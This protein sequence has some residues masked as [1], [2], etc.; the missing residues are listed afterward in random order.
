MNLH[1]IRRSGAFLLSLLLTLSLAVV[2]AAADPAPTPIPTPD[3]TVT[4]TGLSFSSTETEKVKT[5]AVNDTATLTV[6]VTPADAT[7]KL[8]WSVENPTSS[9]VVELVPNA[10]GRE[11]TVTAK[12]PGSATIKVASEGGKAAT[13][14]V[15]V[16]GV[17]LDETS[18]T[19]LVGEM[20][21]LAAQTYGK[22]V[23]SS[24][25]VV[26]SS[27]NISVAEVI[28]GRITGHYPGVATI[29][30]SAGSYSASCTVTV[31]EDVADAINKSASAGE[32]LSFSGLRSDFQNRS[33]DKLGGVGLS[34][35]GSLQV[36]PEQGVLYY[37]YASSDSPGAGVGSENYY[38]NPSG[39]QLGLNELCFVPNIDFSGTAVIYYT[40][41]GTDGRTFRGTVRVSVSTA[42]DVYYSTAADQP[43]Y[44]EAK[45]F[46][47]VCTA[48][49]GKEI[50]SISF[51]PPS[52]KKGV[53]HYNYSTTNVYNPEVSEGLSFYRTKAPYLDSVVF[54]PQ[55]DYSG[56]VEITYRCTT[57]AGTHTGKVRIDVSAA[58]AADSGRITYDVASGGQ[59]DLDADDFQQLSREKTGS[60]LSY[61]YFGQA[62]STGGT[63]YYNYTLSSGY[64]GRVSESTRYYRS[65]TPSISRITFV[66]S[67]AFSGEVTVPFTGYSTNGESFSGEM[68]IRVDEHDGVIAYRS[69]YGE[70]IEFEGA[71][72][73]ELCL[74]Q[75]DRTLNYVTFEQPASGK[76][77]L[78]R[79][80]NYSSGTKVNSTTKFYRSGGSYQIDDVVFVPNSSY[81][82]TFELPFSGYDTSGGRISGVVRITVDRQYGNP[83]VSYYTVSGGFVTFNADDL[84]TACQLRTG[85]RLNYVQF[86][87]PS[88]SVGKLYY[89]YDSD[90]ET[91][92]SVYASTSYYRT[93]SGRVI[94]NVSFRAADS[95]TGTLTV[96][97]TGVS[98]AGT[99]YSGTIEITVSAKEGAFVSYSGSSLPIR[100]QASDFASAHS[101]LT[102][103]TLSYIRFTELPST[104]QGKLYLNYTTPVQSGTAVTQGTSYY[105]SASPSIGQITFV[106]KAGY[107]GSVIL[108]FTGTDTTGRS[109]SGTL[110]L[111]LLDQYCPNNFTDMSGYRNVVPS[112]EFLR[113]L[114]VVKGYGDGTYGPGRSISR[115]EFTVMVYRALELPDAARRDSFPDVSADSYYADAV[116]AAKA[117]GI[118]QGYGNA[119]YPLDTITRQD[120]MTIVLRAMDATGR[121][122][123]GVSTSLLTTYA[124]GNQVAD[125][126][127]M[128]VS[129]FLAT[130][131]AEAD[132]ARYIRPRD[133]MTRAEMAVLLHRI[134]AQ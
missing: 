94:D 35:I 50:V 65:G 31:Q 11:C 81:T 78:Y 134:L 118:V 54:V 89:N 80:R 111:D 16:S 8:T 86:K 40:G 130:G 112:V 93:G 27:T 59:V 109:I 32:A 72:F 68:L 115:G 63:L 126:A 102:G 101:R 122:V 77:T 60:N 15:T 53:L 103:R 12:K 28:D 6:I 132:A 9:G 34:C 64:G 18:L 91:G 121:T 116:A 41:R 97:Y 82:G 73:N 74:N 128:A 90:R 46:S 110:R 84:N 119:F 117:L 105:V 45:D 25:G 44:F 51:V 99:R 62:S 104:S 129:T 88:S 47:A 13:C 95:Y 55:P 75:N 1:T 29:T 133:A 36:S 14:T 124:D 125:Y 57:S 66:A 17:V 100:L 106:P 42:G 39:G 19:M 49:T 71:D 127:R 26:W 98:T 113:S 83:V 7:E 43:V 70:A 2:P 5:M 69:S 56:S 92:T 37:G 76:G 67:N 21:S 33:S 114:G 108:P 4:V 58:P 131:A 120:A 38:V 30:A 48:K 22:A 123:S 87:L 96:Q 79:S 24:T 3:P 52:S 61:V 20:K 10:N 85:E 107:Q 23:N